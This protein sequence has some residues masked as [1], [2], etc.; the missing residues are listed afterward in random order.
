LTRLRRN[1]YNQND[2]ELLAIDRLAVS[3]LKIGIINNIS[4]LD[5]I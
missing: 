3:F 2:S 1:G 5:L 4:R